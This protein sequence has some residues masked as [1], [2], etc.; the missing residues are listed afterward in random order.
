MVD[1]FAIGLCGLASVYLSQDTR[2][3]R[4]RWACIFGL[5]AQPFWL[6]MAWQAHQYGV[7]TL[8]FVYAWLWARGFKLYWLG[9]SETTAEWRPISLGGGRR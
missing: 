3:A 7:L 6:W 1:Q 9:H 4:R 5:L 8:C 2:R